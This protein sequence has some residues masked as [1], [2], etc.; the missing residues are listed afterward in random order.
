MKHKYQKKKHPK[1]RKTLTYIEKITLKKIIDN[2]RT[3]LIIERLYE[4]PYDI[5]IK[6]FNMVIKD[7]MYKWSFNHLVNFRDCLKF[8]NDKPFNYSKDEPRSLWM[9]NN[10]QYHYKHLCQ[11][12]VKKKR[13]PGIMTVFIP[14]C[15]YEEIDNREWLNEPE[16]YWYHIKCRCCKCDHVRVIGQKNLRYNKERYENIEWLGNSPEWYAKSKEQLKYEKN[17]ERCRK[18]RIKK[19]KYKNN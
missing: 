5:K 14:G 6:I 17:I 2:N 1:Y 18:R 15:L 19:N 8:I 11:V 12:N 7:H 10:N 13:Q 4:L 9:I 3:K 16:H